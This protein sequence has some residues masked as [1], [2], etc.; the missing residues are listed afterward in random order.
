MTG[1]T[2]VSV[3]ER[4]LEAIIFDFDGTI[5]DT[6]RDGHRRAYNEAFA[7]LA[8]PWS[9]D[10][11]T[12][13]TWL[14]IAGGKERLAAY[15]A[16]ERPE[17]ADTDT[18]DLV[19]RIHA[20]KARAF[21]RL[22]PALPLRPGIARLVA[23]ARA[24]NVRLAI[25]TTALLDGVEAYVASHAELAGAFAFVGAG[26]V[27]ARK[28]PAP[29]IYTYVLEHLGLD[30]AR[31]IAIEDSANGL[32]AARAARLATI[33]TVSSYTTDEDFAGAAAVLSDLGEAERPATVLAGPAPPAGVATVD[34]LDAVLRLR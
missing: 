11:P 5:S 27:V 21:A 15:I 34:Y 23:E 14:A 25:A 24:A 9:W 6:E 32:R 28:K 3:N 26:D 30:P 7:E 22:A 2:D 33:V 17:L 13:G 20:T 1:R 19:R 16:R 12:Y 18:G 8:L 29:D 31:A 4:A 10:V